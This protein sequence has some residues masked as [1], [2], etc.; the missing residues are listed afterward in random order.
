M[1]ARRRLVSFFLM[2]SLSVLQS[3][4][5]VHEEAHPLTLPDLHGSIVGPVRFDWVP[6]FGDKI[7]FSI[8]ITNSGSALPLTNIYV[9]PFLL[10]FPD[11]NGDAPWDGI[12]LPLKRY[13]LALGS[14]NSVVV[15]YSGTLPKLKLGRYWV[16][17][18]IDSKNL[19][20][21]DNEL[22]NVTDGL[23]IG[24]SVS[25]PHAPPPSRLLSD[26][27]SEIDGEIVTENGGAAHTLRTIVQGARIPEAQ[28]ENLWVRFM[29]ADLATGR[30][31]TL[32][33]EEGQAEKQFFGLYWQREGTK[34]VDYYYQE[35]SIQG[36]GIGRYTFLTL[37]DSHDN[38]SEPNEANN[39]D[40]YPLLIP[41]FEIVDHPKEVWL[42]KKSNEL[43][44]P[45]QTIRIRNVYS[46]PV[47]WSA[48]VP[49]WLVTDPSSGE[50]G[51]GADIPVTVRMASVALLPG[52]YT[53]SLRFVVPSGTLQ[54]AALTVPVALYIHGTTTP[55][56]LVSPP[57]LESS[58]PA[59]QHP[60][61]LSLSVA[62][63]GNATLYWMAW[64]DEDWITIV[65]P[66]SR[67]VLPAGTQTA[68]VIIH[69]EGLLPGI[70]VGHILI[71]NNASNSPTVVEVQFQ[72]L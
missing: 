21:E 26:L 69:P 40:A 11:A 68:K 27:Y 9:K 35:P 55:Q 12:V 33:H 54:N 31:Y 61:E 4:S 50:I 63:T 3:L 14:G 46:S 62:N 41:P 39:L 49:N 70:H 53:T 17:A 38:F 10:P 24:R 58:A 44:P 2:I 28:S 20:E 45:E 15:S 42:V 57:R 43:V 34:W 32:P 56:L 29:L 23:D 66:F 65:K 47:L 30:L 25:Q 71:F 18:V 60:P 22:N 48:S 67:R 5:F 16:A 36:I 72:V 59:G 8:Q 1:S 64:Q 13:P 7:L 51:A 52:T 37:M 6:G 19:V